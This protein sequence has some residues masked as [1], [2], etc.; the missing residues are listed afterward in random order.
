MAHLSKMVHKKC[1]HI[2]VYAKFT[3]D[4]FPVTSKKF[5]D[6]AFTKLA[7][8]QTAKHTQTIKDSV[9]HDFREACD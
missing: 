4:A 1:E 6:P 7:T 5:D 8:I 2:G 3:S 9:G